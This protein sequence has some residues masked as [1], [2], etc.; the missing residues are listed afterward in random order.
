MDDS[1]MGQT[2]SRFRRVAMVDRVVDL[3]ADKLN[4]ARRCELVQ[5]VQFCVTNRGAGRIVRTVDQD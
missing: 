5:A 3:I 1:G 4:F 2:G